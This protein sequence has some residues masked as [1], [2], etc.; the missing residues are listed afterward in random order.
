MKVERI[1]K[2]LT[3][4]TYNRK[5]TTMFNDYN[6]SGNTMPS[7]MKLSENILDKISDIKIT[8]FII[9]ILVIFFTVFVYFFIENK[10]NKVGEYNQEEIDV[11]VTEKDGKRTYTK[12][13]NLLNAFVSVILWGF[14]KQ[15]F[16]YL[17]VNNKP[18]CTIRSLRRLEKGKLLKNEG[19]ISKCLK[20]A[21]ASH[22][23]LP[24]GEISLSLKSL[25]K[26]GIFTR[27]V[28]KK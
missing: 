13:E 5:D 11:L 16:T 14:E 6:H 4:S 8:N 7:L 21:W 22:L 2:I 23:K 18:V 10:I 15:K 3:K 24:I 20:A 25:E 9:L 19:Y 12:N 26:M 1:F 17:N 27:Q 28:L